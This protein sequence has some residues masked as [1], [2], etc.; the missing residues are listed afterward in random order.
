MGQ[1]GR[2]LGCAADRL[3]HSQPRPRPSLITSQD[4][5]ASP[6]DTLAGQRPLSPSDKRQ[7]QGL[8]SKIGRPRLRAGLGNTRFAEVQ[9]PNGQP[10]IFSQRTLQT[11]ARQGAGPHIY[12]GQ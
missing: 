4:V 3:T 7:H 12:Q 2:S 6:Q 5:L 1:V 8:S 9:A 11:W 10:R